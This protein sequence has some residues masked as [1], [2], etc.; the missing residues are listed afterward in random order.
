M[1]EKWGVNK[2]GKANQ[3]RERD[4]EHNKLVMDGKGE[5]KEENRDPRTNPIVPMSNQRM[6]PDYFSDIGEKHSLCEILHCNRFLNS[7]KHS[8]LPL[9]K[10][11]Q[12]IIS[13]NLF[14]KQLGF[15]LLD[16]I[17]NIHQEL[18]F[19]RLDKTHI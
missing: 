9:V 10:F 7:Q 17:R 11:T 15:A 1:H 5:K 3:E 14:L 12:L 8:C 13:K 6:K 4:P 18:M 19:F 2:I 16:S